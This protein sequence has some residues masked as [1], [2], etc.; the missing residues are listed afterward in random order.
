[1][2][3]Q[4]V[5]EASCK[6]DCVI[7]FGDFVR[8]RSRII[9]RSTLIDDERSSNV[10][11]I[12][13][14]PNVESICLAEKFPVDRA[15]FISVD[16]GAMLLEV[17]TCSDMSRAMY[18]T[19]YTFDDVLGQQLECGDLFKVRRFDPSKEG[20]GAQVGLARWGDEDGRKNGCRKASAK[21][22]G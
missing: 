14:L 16:I 15:D 19:G 7:M 8:P 20:I 12:F 11:L 2:G 13:V 4:Q 6:P 9:H 1:M 3:H 10:C 22:L 5:G 17:D 18:P 21:S